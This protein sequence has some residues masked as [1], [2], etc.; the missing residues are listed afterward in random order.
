MKQK[1][2]CMENVWEKMFNYICPDE[3]TV[4]FNFDVRQSCRA[5]R[6]LFLI[7]KPFWNSSIKF[8]EKLKRK[9][10]TIENVCHFVFN[11]WTSV[12]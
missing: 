11:F 12:S 6:A 3:A 9:T 5:L 2:K 1:S 7:W 10:I 4:G 8:W